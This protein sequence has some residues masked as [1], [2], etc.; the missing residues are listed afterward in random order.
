MYKLLT[1]LFITVFPAAWNAQTI[2]PYSCDNLTVDSIFTCKTNAQL[3]S[4]TV[5]NHDTTQTWGPTFFAIMSPAG[6]T[7]ATYVTCGCVVILRGKT[8]TINFPARDTSFRVPA[9]YCCSLSMTGSNVICKKTYNT[10][11][12]AGIPTIAPGQGA[13]KLFPNPVQDNLTLDLG[14]DPVSE[15]H[16]VLMNMQGQEILSEALVSEQS[17]VSLAGISKG[18]YIVQLYRNG[19]LTSSEKLIR[20]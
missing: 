7:V 19:V 16:F 11:S 12:F 17:N 20:N 10:C 3:I 4:L 18:I 8:G 14:T 9:R 6:D 13:M 15:C 1:L 5:T 2:A